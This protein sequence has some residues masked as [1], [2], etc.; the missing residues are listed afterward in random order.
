MILLRERILRVIVGSMMSLSSV[1]AW[2][3]SQEDPGADVVDVAADTRAAPEGDDARELE[4]VI[5]TAQKL[6]QAIQ[7]VPLSIS[8]IPAGD[9]VR[10]GVFDSGS[11][12]ERVPNVEIDV[13]AQAPVIGIRGFSTDT[14]NVGF[15]PAV[16]LVFDD[17]PLGRPEFISD[18]LFD[19]DHVEVL[20]GPQGTLFGKNTIAGVIA[21]KTVEPTMDGRG[22]LLATVD[23][24]GSTRAEAAQS[25][26]LGKSAALRIAGVT[27]NHDGDL[28]NTTRDR[29]INDF[30]QNAG[31][32]KLSLWSND[33]LTVQL[34]TQIS[35]T[36]GAYGPLQLYDASDSVLAF[37]R[38]Y[39]PDVEDDPLDS[40]TSQDLQGRFDRDTDISRILVNYALDDH[41]GLH[42]LVTTFVAAHAGVDLKAMID[43]DVSPAALA[44]TDFGLDDRQNSLEWRLAGGSDT[45]FG[46]GEQTLFVVGVYAFQAKLTSHLDALGGDDLI[47]FGASPAGIEALGGPNAEGLLPLFAL[48][49][50]FPGLPL[51][52]SVLRDYRQKTHSEAVFGQIEWQLDDAW[53]AIVGARLTQENKR[54]RQRVSS[55][56]LGIVK[57]VLGSENFDARRHRS[58]TDFS[59]KLGAIYRWS[60]DLN[61]FVT[62]TRGFKSGG[63]NAIADTKDD[64]EFEPERATNLEAGLKATWWGGSLRTNLSVYQ[65]A[66]SDL[67]VIDLLGPS[68]KVGNAAEAR[69]RGVEAEVSWLPSARWLRIDAALGFSDA[70]YRRYRDAVPTEQQSDDGQDSQDLSGRTLPNAPEWSALLSPTVILPW[71]FGYGLGLECSVDAAYRGD[72]YSATDLDPHSHQKGYWLFGASMALG[73]KKHGWTLVMSGTNLADEKA[74]DL[75]IDDSV[76]DNTYTG[77]QIPRRRVQVSL[78]VDW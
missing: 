71:S 5:V 32:A 25:L 40:R 39:D 2:A 3:Q 22:H 73:Q 37:T 65:T 61:L 29:K 68:L 33:A 15:E 62:A 59:P 54:A 1:A 78:V 20:R 51:D 4:T 53:S 70:E 35:S 10:S 56:G 16:G 26:S 63:Y 27:W 77:E 64:L 47:A 13:D 74:L 9:L 38:R 23:E 24:R 60:D 75:V 49:P 6:T 8:V 48:L 42:D 58:E 52:D 31:R 17:V 67:Q 46:L 36:K 41:F 66:V 19:L 50:P 57:L 72:Q 69:L 14:D 43:A 76:Y 28:E 55:T 30:E 7:D 45:L 18:G 12:E 34:S 44:V 21:F 11:L